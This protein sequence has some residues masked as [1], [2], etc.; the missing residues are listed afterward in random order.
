[1]GGRR[2]MEKEGS[3]E[4]RGEASEFFWP[5]KNDGPPVVEAERRRQG[6]CDCAN[7]SLIRGKDPANRS[8]SHPRLS[9]FFLPQQR[10]NC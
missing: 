7:V 8:R 2:R 10:K 6:R 9:Y 4:G 3:R 5:E 1:M